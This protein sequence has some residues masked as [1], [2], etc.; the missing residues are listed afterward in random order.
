VG[1]AAVFFV[2]VAALLVALGDRRRISYLSA[3]VPL[4]S[5]GLAI[6]LLE[7]GQVIFAGGLCI[8]VACLSAAAV[9][10][11]QL[12]RAGVRNGRD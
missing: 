6:P 11:Y 9:Q 2:G 5:F 1:A 3:A 12:R 10:S 4:M 8:A 7:R